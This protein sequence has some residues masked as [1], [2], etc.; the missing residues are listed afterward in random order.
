MRQVDE[1]KAVTR[2]MAQAYRAAFDAS[3]N[4]EYEAWAEPGTLDGDKRWMICKHTYTSGNLTKTEWADGSATG[5][6]RT[7]TGYSGYTY[8]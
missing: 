1:H 7:W 6:N 5:F 4:V 8:S 3:N 2:Q